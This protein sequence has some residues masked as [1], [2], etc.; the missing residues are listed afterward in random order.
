MVDPVLLYRYI[1]ELTGKY[2]RS[3]KMWPPNTPEL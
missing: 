3:L 1:T 2:E